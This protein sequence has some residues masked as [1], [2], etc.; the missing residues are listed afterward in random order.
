MDR[1]FVGVEST[2]DKRFSGLQSTVDVRFAQVS[3]ELRWLKW[4]VVTGIAAT[5]W[6]T[7]SRLVL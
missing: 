4:L 5:V 7:L 3:T 1:R 2:M 6:P